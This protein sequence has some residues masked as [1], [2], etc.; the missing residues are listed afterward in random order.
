[1]AELAAGAV[2]S[3]LGVIRSEARLLRLV[4]SDVQFIKEEMES[5]NSFLAHLARWA[6]PGGDHDE[7]VRTWMN[8][9]RL[10]AQDCNNCIDLYLYRGNPDIHR[11]KG[12]LRRYLWWVPWFLHKLVAQHRAAIQL[13]ELKDR[14][15]DVGE[16]RLRYGV[17][18]PAKSAAGQSTPVASHGLTSAA[19]LAP[20]LTHA[21]SPH[22]AGGYA[23][24][25]DEEDGDDQP[26]AAALT[27][28]SDQ[29]ALFSRTLDDYVKAKLWEWR[30]GFKPNA[31]ETMSTVIV[32]PKRA[33]DAYAVVYET[34]VFHPG[35]KLNRGYN[36]AVVIDIPALHPDYLPLRT[37]EILYYILRELKLQHLPSQSQEQDSDDSD[38]E[39]EDHE[40]WQVYF[41]KLHIYR[42]KKRVFKRIRENIKKMKIFEKLDKIQS[43]MQ[44][45]PPK[46]QQKKSMD[47]QDP[48]VH[49]L[50]KKLLWSAAVASASQHEQLKN[51]EVPKLTASDDTIKAIAKKLKQHMEADEQGGG[52]EEGGEEKE[53]GAEV[54]VEK[55]EHEAGGK[56]EAAE[57]E[58][59]GGEKGIV[60][61]E[62]EGGV[63]GVAR[64]A[65]EE[66]ESGG[67]EGEKE[68][69]QESEGHEDDEDDESDDY[70]YDYYDDDDDDDQEQEERQHIGPIYLDEV[71]YVHILRKV[72]P[73]TSNNIKS[74]T[75][76]DANTILGEDQIKQIIHETKEEILRELQVN[77]LDK[78]Q[79]S[80]E[81]SSQGQNTEAIFMEIM[82]QKMDK[83]KLELKE[84]LKIKGLVDDIKHQLRRECPLFILEVDDTVELPRWE[85]TRNALTLL[86]C[87]ADVLIVTTVK[88]IKQAKEC[89]YPQRE[90]ID[91]S[92]AGLYYDTVLEITS[93]QKD[94]DNYNPQIFRNILEECEPHEDCMKIFTHTIYI[95]PRRSS[96][97]LNKLYRNLQASPKSFDIVARKMLKF[98][99]S[100]MPK[101]YKSCLLYL[102]IFPPGYKIRRSTLIERWVTE[103]LIFRDDWPSSMHRANRCFDE[104][105][106]RWLI[107][108]ADIGARGMVKTCMVNDPVHGFITKI[109]RK[110]HIVETR[111]SHHLARHFSVFNDLQLRSSDKITGFFERLSTSS[112]VSLLKVLDL[113]GCQCFGEKNQN[114]LNDICSKM[115]LLKYLSLKGTDIKQL[116]SKI[117]N[118]RE[119]EVLDIRETKVPMNSTANVLLLKLKRL[120]AGHT[121]HSP[122]NSQ[123]ATAIGVKEL[124]STVQIPHKIEKMVNIEV[125]HNVKARSSHDLR[126]IGKLWQLR[127]LGV[128]IDDTSSH[129]KNFLRAVSDL[130]EC[131]Y[132]LSITLPMDISEGVPSEQLPLSLKNHPKVLESLSICGTTQK[133]HLLPLFTK[134]DNNKL[135]KVTLSSTSLNQEIF[136]VLAKLPTLQFVRLRDIT[137]TESVLIFKE[138]EYKHLKYILVEGSSFT[139]IIFEDG[140][141]P[142]LNNMVLSFTNINSVFGVKG[143]ENLEAVELRMR[144]SRSSNMGTLLSAFSNSN[145]ISK[146]ILRLEQGDEQIQNPIVFNE[147]DFP[148]LK[149]LTVDCS[150]IMDIVF[151][152]GSASKLERI[153][154][155]SLASFSDLNN[156]PKLKEL[157]LNGDLVP[158]TVKEAI[159]NHKNKP[160][161]NHNKPE[162]QDQAKGEEQDEDEDSARFPFCWKKHV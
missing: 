44:T 138:D 48:N 3:L 122:R 13:R 95:N 158:N 4:R 14:A 38:G 61:E 100:D 20:S 62:Y 107:H 140:A 8:Q 145:Q 55:E 98:S 91:Y 103:G 109:A 7:Q 85:E 149:L 11:A 5:M 59:S 54:G 153:V 128:V 39:E 118:L 137:S 113:E 136:E 80:G 87:S 162:I 130:H 121:Y 45:R 105:I 75:K 2:T 141:A 146:L 92:L 143:L 90:P 152:S 73:K 49:V 27:D 60:E 148:Q 129:L 159:R 40:S 157:Q 47:R 35:Y 155:S 160:M 154:C 1:M 18:V 86:G 68:I 139:T 133:V 37:K 46:G 42:E 156:L 36:R 102:A 93:K 112:R 15:R 74:T 12:G 125:L 30:T 24:G 10:L 82:K 67:E 64:N 84:Q 19:S 97:E 9:V 94:E 108:P 161:L 65:V 119:L 117:N 120:L 25:D 66:G 115:L 79:E 53:G 33:L 132:S 28:Y 78:F 71:Q 123:A 106:N 6:P 99:Y 76:Q 57:E 23:A 32:D 126:D 21:A 43:D 144:S 114:Y 111:L 134:D 63:G 58:G 29:R 147:D 41:K 34:A 89:C 142:E 52:E 150:A 72:F 70:D 69:V 17:E 22:P 135:V 116:P 131:L 50:L 110:Q 81:A 83:L 77:K 51:K 16:R 124:V 88:D 31:G 151:N 104:L 101:E 56:N 127:K 26:L 96:E